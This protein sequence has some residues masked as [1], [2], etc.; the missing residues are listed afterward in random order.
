MLLLMII[1]ACVIVLLSW[2]KLHFYFQEFNDDV[3]LHKQDSGL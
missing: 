3:G 1:W 2:K